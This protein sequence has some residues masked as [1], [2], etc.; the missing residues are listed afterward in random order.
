M[1]YEKLKEQVIWAVTHFGLVNTE[2]IMNHLSKTVQELELLQPKRSP[3]PDGTL[4]LTEEE[5]KEFDKVSGYNYEKYRVHNLTE[6]SRII[7]GCD[8]HLWWQLYDIKAIL[9]LAERFNLEVK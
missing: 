7:Q 5:F 1:R 8:G 9:W 3:L 2:D 4:L 6:E